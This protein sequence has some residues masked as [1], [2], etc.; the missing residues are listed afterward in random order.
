MIAAGIFAAPAYY[1]SG[2]PCADCG[3][4]H[5]DKFVFVVFGIVVPL[6]MI[7]FMPAVGAFGIFEDSTHWNGPLRFRLTLQ[8]GELFFAK[9]KVS[10]RKDDYSQIVIGCVQGF[11]T[12]KGELDQ[13]IQIFML[14]LD[15]NGKWRRFLIS[16]DYVPWS[17]GSK[18]F[19]EVVEKLQPYLA[20]EQFVKDYSKDECLEQ[21]NGNRA[22]H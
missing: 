7:V 18:R 13:S 19:K 12:S 10:W 11:N 21:Q 2:Q 1:F 15:R 20:F 4:Q 16:D 17:R 9:E 22:V 3:N 6:A 14:V 5:D 8:S